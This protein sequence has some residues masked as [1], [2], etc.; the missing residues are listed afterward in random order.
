[1]TPSS[2]FQPINFAEFL[3]GYPFARKED[4]ELIEAMLGTINTPHAFAC[5]VRSTDNGE[6]GI[7]G[8]VSRLDPHL[9]E[10]RL[11]ATHDHDARTRLNGLTQV[12]GALVKAVIAANGG[13]KAGVDGEMPAEL[14]YFAKT[15]AMFRVQGRN[16]EN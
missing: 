6:P 9:A 12:A 15:A 11:Q 2:A 8:V 16:T 13:E 14:H 3:G 5:M 10:L 4:Y 7:A 1:M